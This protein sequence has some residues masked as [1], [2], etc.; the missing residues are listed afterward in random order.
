MSLKYVFKPYSKKF[1]ELFAKEKLRLSSL[2]KTASLIEHVGSTAVPNL[3]GK[4]IIDIAIGAAQQDIQTISEHLQALGYEFRPAH[5]TPD[6][7]FFRIDLPDQDEGT[8]RHHVHLM[9]THSQELKE[10]VLFRD[11]L[12][13][14]PD[15]AEKYASLKKTAALE[16][17]QDGSKYRSLKKPLIEGMLNH[18]AGG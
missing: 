6:R 1:P 12:R 4:G 5:S 13:N 8:R 10:M 16:S 18:G 11:H 3:G 17:D 2:I 7:L 9:P 15:E 14:H